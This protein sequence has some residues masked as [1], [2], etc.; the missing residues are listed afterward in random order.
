MSNKPTECSECNPGFEHY[1]FSFGEGFACVA[2]EAFPSGARSRE[3]YLFNIFASSSPSVHAS[4]YGQSDKYIE[5]G[6]A[7]FE[8]IPIYNRG[9]YFDGS[10]QI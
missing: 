7:N 3:N 4:G 5:S 9:L 2:L 1:N 6:E 10:A 8:P